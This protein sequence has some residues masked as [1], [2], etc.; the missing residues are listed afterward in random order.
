[1]VTLYDDR[2]FFEMDSRLRRNDGPV[3]PAAA[4]HFNGDAQKL[5]ASYLPK[6]FCKAKAA[7]GYRLIV[8][9]PSPLI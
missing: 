7:A 5:R 4:D 6:S 8:N 9:R 3:C 1:M 2:V